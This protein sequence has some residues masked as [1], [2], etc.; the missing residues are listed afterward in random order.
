MSNTI[1]SVQSMIS[2]VKMENIVLECVKTIGFKIIILVC[3]KYYSV[4]L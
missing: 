2:E 1:R 4:I 3:T